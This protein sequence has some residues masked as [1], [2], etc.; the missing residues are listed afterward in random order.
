MANIK[1]R[2]I[3]DRTTI[4]A[5]LIRQKKSIDDAARILKVPYSCVLNQAKRL[6]TAEELEL[7]PRKR[8]RYTLREKCIVLWKCQKKGYMAVAEDTGIHPSQLRNWKMK[9]KNDLE[10][11]KARVRDKRRRRKK[12]RQS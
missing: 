5:L 2:H 11:F 8:Q 12:N 6:L 10:L 4:H 3:I 1:Y 7:V 9:H